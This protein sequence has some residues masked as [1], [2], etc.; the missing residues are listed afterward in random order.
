LRA[1]ATIAAA[2]RRAAGRHIG[3]AVGAF[4]QDR[5]AAFDLGRLGRVGPFEFEIAGIDEAPALALDQQ[6]RAAEHVAGRKQRQ[7]VV[8]E[9]PR[10]VE[11][12]RFEDDLA[13]ARLAE[14]GGRLRRAP[15]EAVRADP[16]VVG[17]VITTSW[18]RAWSA[19][20]WET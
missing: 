1:Q 13:C 20:P 4:H 5:V 17:E 12:V 2:T 3:A 8:A 18:A 9:P 19:W 15:A 11:S 16:G 7:L 14:Q 10:F 6:L